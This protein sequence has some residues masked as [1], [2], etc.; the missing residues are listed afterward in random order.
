[1]QVALMVEPQVGG[2]YDDLLALAR[3]TEGHGLESL[4]RSDHYLNMGDSTHATDALATLAGLARDTERI[5]LTVLVSPITFRHPAVIAKT[6]ATIGEMSGGRFRLGVGTGW[7]E[8]EH[9]AFGMGLPPL[10]E[11][12]DRFE[13]AL[14]YLWAAFG[15]ADG[16][17]S[18]SHYQLDD[19]EVNPRVGTSVPIIIGGSGMRRTPTLAG[20]FADEYNMFATD[21]E[22]LERR[23]TV[24]REA[25]IAAGRDPNAIILSMVTSPILGR[26]EREYQDILGARA[27]A[28]DM[29]PEAYAARLDAIGMPHGTPERVAAKYGEIASWGVGRIYLQN[30]AALGDIDT[31]MNAVAVDIVR[32][33]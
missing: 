28:R 24:M 9:A 20:R 6:A 10:G 15:R 16:G 33:I 13:E 2:T 32:S 11:R 12:F 17:F 19:I 27:A 22:T 4:A 1:M 23:R 7:M 5:G 14:G 29:D 25:A 21:Q 26:D 18:G 3:W 31:D 8:P 30:F